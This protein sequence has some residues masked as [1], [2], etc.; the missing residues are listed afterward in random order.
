MYNRPLNLTVPVGTRD[1]EALQ[2][3][4]YEQQTQDLLSALLEEQSLADIKELLLPILQ[5]IKDNPNWDRVFVQPLGFAVFTLLRSQKHYLRLHLWSPEHF[6]GLDER[7]KIHSHKGHINSL[8]VLGELN[9]TRVQVQQASEGHYKL[10]QFDYHGEQSA[11]LKQTP[12]IVNIT[13]QETE[14]IMPGQY[15]QVAPGE[16]HTASGQAGQ[17]GVTLCVFTQEDSDSQTIPYNIASTDFPSEV[18][19]LKSAI[20]EG[21]A[22]S[23]LVKVILDS[24]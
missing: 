6:P 13:A 1:H 7:I 23:R 22:V 2:G 18:T 21:Q 10:M 9:H 17:I 4:D 3:F 14:Q 8:V 24:L 12:I 15:Y 16:Y 5:H 11:T 19:Q 20:A